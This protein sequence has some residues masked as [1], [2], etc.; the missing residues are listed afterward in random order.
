MNKSRD[1]LIFQIVNW[2]ANFLWFAYF[3]RT[4]DPTLVGQIAAAE[5]SVSFIGVFFLSTALRVHDEYGGVFIDSEVRLL[6]LKFLFLALILALYFLK[7]VDFPLV[8][9]S[10]SVLSIPVH[11]PI[12]LGHQYWLTS[13]LAIKVIGIF[14]MYF[15]PASLGWMNSISHLTWIYF[16]PNL[17]YGVACYAFYLYLLRN[18]SS[19]L[20]SNV[21]RSF[22][23]GR[24]FSTLVIAGII[25]VYQGVIIKSIVHYS[26]NLALLE[27]IIRSAYSFSFPYIIRRGLLVKMSNF[28]Y[29]ILGVVL[30]AALSAVY[31]YFPITAILLPVILDMYMTMLSGR[32]LAADAALILAIQILGYAF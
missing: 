14:L 30:I 21:S 11:L 23:G 4:F 26:Q 17:A 15:S 1:I 10:M 27:R 19:G 12:K 20:E 9:A 8:I 7:I 24:V 2:S 25:N 29:A 18:R 13:I 5:V 22:L 6:L 31:V 16:L 28:S 3:I 32:F